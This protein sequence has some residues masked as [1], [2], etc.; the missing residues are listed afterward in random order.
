MSGSPAPFIAAWKPSAIESTATNTMTTPTIPSTATAEDPRRCLIELKLTAVTARIC[1][2]M[3]PRSTPSERV[4]D[5]QPLRLDRRQDASRQSERGD[6]TDPECRVTGRQIDR[7]QQP[8]RR[9]ADERD[10]APRQG[11]AR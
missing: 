10:C 1:P 3:R 9:I 4:D 8:M 11:E 2:I 6:Q 5:L 7:R